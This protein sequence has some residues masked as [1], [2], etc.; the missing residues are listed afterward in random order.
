MTGAQPAKLDSDKFGDEAARPNRWLYRIMTSLKLPP[1]SGYGIERGCEEE[2]E[3]VIL[4][5]NLL[6][7]GLYAYQRNAFVHKRRRK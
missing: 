7:G 6:H 5:G 1:L 3:G 2:G 4:S